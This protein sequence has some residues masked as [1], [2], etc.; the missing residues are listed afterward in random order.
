MRLPHT[1]TGVV[2][3]PHQSSPIDDTYCRDIISNAT[4]KLFTIFYYIQMSLFMN[5]CVVIHR[6]HAKFLADLLVPSYILNVL[7]AV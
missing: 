3:V 2:F 1:R 6:R 7:K 4:S 5:R